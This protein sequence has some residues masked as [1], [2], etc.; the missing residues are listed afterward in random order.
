MKINFCPNTPSVNVG[1]VSYISWENSEFQDHMRKLFSESPRE[2]LIELVIERDG[3]K[4]FFEMKK[5]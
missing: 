4:A 3:I 1:V 5:A 2:R